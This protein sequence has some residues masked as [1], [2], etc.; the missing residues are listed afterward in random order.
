MICL[1]SKA[2]SEG[3]L[4]MA[5]Y[6]VVGIDLAEN[7]TEYNYSSSNRE[8]Y[9]PERPLISQRNGSIADERQKSEKNG[10]QN[11]LNLNIGEFLPKKSIAL[12]TKAKPSESLQPHRV[13]FV[14]LT[15]RLTTCTLPIIIPLLLQQFF[16]LQI[17]QLFSYL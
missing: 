12:G 7:A 11:I 5:N 9:I 4:M 14:T 2:F 16:S 1:D 10:V 6:C 8:K 15:I 3:T 17:M 13:A